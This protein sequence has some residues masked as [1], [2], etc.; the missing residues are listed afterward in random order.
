MA[1]ASACH[2]D[3][4]TPVALVELG[5]TQK[6]YVI[7]EDGGSIKIAVF[8]N[9]A[10]HIDNLDEAKWLALDKTSG[11]GDDSL[12]VT[13]TMNEEFKRMSRIVLCSDVDSR[14]DTISI[15]QKGSLVA[16]LTK[17]N[18]SIVLPGAG[19]TVTES[20]ST[21]VPFSYMTVDI[22]YPEGAPSGWVK[23]VT[24]DDQSR[25][26]GAPY[27]GH[28]YVVHRRMGRPGLG[29]SESGPAQRQRGHRSDHS[30]QRPV[31]GLFHG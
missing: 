25:R 14:R 15:K 2:Y 10:Y 20:V 29:A 11:V 18:T 17:E 31:R 24:I 28:Q 23:D 26:H 7:D 22:E 30:L 27:R 21:N 9:G 13:A 6:E 3:D 16:A 12:K 8:S 4:A 5:A 19:G 1:V